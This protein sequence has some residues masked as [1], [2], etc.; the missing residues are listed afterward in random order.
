M[1]ILAAS[2]LFGEIHRGA[3]ISESRRG[4][5]KYGRRRENFIDDIA[6]A[7]LLIIGRKINIGTVSLMRLCV[8]EIDSRACNST[9][10]ALGA[11][12]RVKH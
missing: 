7:P 1:S 8:G 3:L 11:T 5:Y 10:R 6:I 4:K 9:R 12:M 2:G